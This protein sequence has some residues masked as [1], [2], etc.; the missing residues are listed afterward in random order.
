MGVLLFIVIFW[1]VLLP[2][3]GKNSYVVP[4]QFPEDTAVVF[5]DLAVSPIQS[6]VA[7]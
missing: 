6:Q 2:L 1:I 7:K 3:V 5:S 4:L